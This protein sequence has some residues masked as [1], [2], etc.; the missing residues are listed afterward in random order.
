MIS[1]VA[2]SRKPKYASRTAN[3]PI[4]GIVE[5]SESIIASNLRLDGVEG[6]IDNNKSITKQIDQLSQPAGSAMAATKKDRN[7]PKP[8]ITPDKDEKNANAEVK[9]ANIFLKLHYKFNCEAK[10]CNPANS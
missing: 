8:I 10:K 6:N 4:E 2:I 5:E 9:K 1:I 7:T 3:I